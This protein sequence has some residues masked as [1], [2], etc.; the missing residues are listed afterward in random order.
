LRIAD[1]GEVVG[2]AWW[3]FDAVTLTDKGTG[4]DRKAGRS[5]HE[6]R[7]NGDGREAVEGRSERIEVGERELLRFA[8]RPVTRRRMNNGCCVVFVI[9]L[10]CEKR[11]RWA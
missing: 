8:V 11:G 10:F 3:R 7:R 6:A 9:I 1:V 2:F 5:V 4:E